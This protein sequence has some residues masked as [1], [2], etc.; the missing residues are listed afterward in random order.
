[1]SGNGREWSYY[2]G[3]GYV[4]RA[5][6][7]PWG[8]ERTLPRG[9]CR[10]IAAVVFHTNQLSFRIPS[11]LPLVRSAT[12]WPCSLVSQLKIDVVIYL[13]SRSD[14]CTYSNAINALPITYSG[15]ENR[16]RKGANK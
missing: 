6:D 5:L 3:W 15:R 12:I 7:R 16:T 11:H 4:G 1:M 9:C 2:S 13:N 10:F 14:Q 8:L